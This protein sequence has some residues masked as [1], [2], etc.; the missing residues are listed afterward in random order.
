V[1]KSRVGG[2]WCQ[3]CPSLMSISSDKNYY[4]GPLSHMN[5]PTSL[6][7]IISDFLIVMDQYSISG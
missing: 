2:Q 3:E 7:Q 1:N 6:Y 4:L 5:K